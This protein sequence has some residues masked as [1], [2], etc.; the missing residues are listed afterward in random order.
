MSSHRPTM[1]RKIE[2]G[3]IVN[4]KLLILQISKEIENFTNLEM[5]ANANVMVALPNTGGALYSTP[6]SLAD[7]YYY[8]YNYHIKMIIQHPTV[9]TALGIEINMGSA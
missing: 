2:I 8:N 1:R 6:Q 9:K 4:K 7:A 5:W 3:E